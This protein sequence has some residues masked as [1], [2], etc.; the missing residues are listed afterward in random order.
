MQRNTLDAGASD[1]DC[2][3][4][5]HFP[6]NALEAISTLPRGIPNCTFQEWIADRDAFVTRD[7]C[8]SRLS[9]GK[10]AP[11][12]RNRVLLD[13]FGADGRTSSTASEKGE[14]SS[15][16]GRECLAAVCG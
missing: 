12:R 11:P 13:R 15:S 1:Y 10:S 2:V 16:R 6:E 14:S 5:L 4:E 8:E 9:D 7:L 3:G